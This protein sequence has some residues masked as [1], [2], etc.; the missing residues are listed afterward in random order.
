MLAKAKIIEVHNWLKSDSSIAGKE[1]IDQGWKPAYDLRTWEEF[2]G[3]IAVSIVLGSIVFGQKTRGPS[4]E[5]S[6]EANSLRTTVMKTAQLSEPPTPAIIDRELG[7]DKVVSGLLVDHDGVS[8]REAR[9]K[10]KQLDDDLKKM[11]LERFHLQQIIQ[12][13]DKER[14]LKAP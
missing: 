4:Q 10:I 8:E 7:S 12:G 2:P 5:S 9:M 11:Q 14:G 6:N 13:Y 3:D 1:D